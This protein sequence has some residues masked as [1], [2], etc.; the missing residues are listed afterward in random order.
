MKLFSPA[1][2]KK[3]KDEIRLQEATAGLNL[4][5]KV[6]ELR[7]KSSLEE[8]KAKEASLKIEQDFL[9]RFHALE[10]QEKTLKKE[11]QELQKQKQKLLE[12]IENIEK[13]A[14]RKKEQAEKMLILANEQRKEVEKKSEDMATKTM[15]LMEKTDELHDYEEKLKQNFIDLE[16]RK[17]FAD[18]SIKRADLVW[19]EMTERINAVNKGLDARAKKITELEQ[20]ILLQRKFL[21]EK[22]LDIEKEKKHIESQQKTLK[23]AFEELRN[24]SK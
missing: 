14:E 7:R 12:P 16:Q 5:K 21:E 24:K 4:A 3:K 2:I 15:L 6:D 8:L 23:A 17:E 11:V 9:G 22:E 18:I 1:E 20:T 10:T 19:K 13:E